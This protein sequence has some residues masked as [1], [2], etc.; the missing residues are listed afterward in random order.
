MQQKDVQEK[1]IQEAV[2]QAYQKPQLGKVRLFAD[3]VLS[4]FQ[5]PPCFPTGGARDGVST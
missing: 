2:K 3:Q 1:R 4:C 5:D